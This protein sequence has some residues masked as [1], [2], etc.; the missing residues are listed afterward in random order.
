[1]LESLCGK[2][3]DRRDHWPA[4][5]NTGGP[6]SSDSVRQSHHHNQHQHQS[7]DG[8]LYSRGPNELRKLKS[9]STT[10]SEDEYGPCSV[11]SARR[12]Q[13]L[14]TDSS[15]GA[16]TASLTPIWPHSLSQHECTETGPTLGIPQSRSFSGYCRKSITMDNL[17]TRSPTFVMNSL[18]EAISADMDSSNR[19]LP[20]SKTS[21]MPQQHPPTTPT[22][23]LTITRQNAVTSEYALLSP[24]LTHARPLKLTT[25]QKISLQNTWRIMKD[26]SVDRISE[27][28][29]QKLINAQ[30]KVKDVFY[31][32]AFLTIFTRSNS[33]TT[34]RDHSR[35]LVR[36]INDLV[37]HVDKCEEQMKQIRECGMRHV[38]LRQSGFKADIWE[39]FG[40]AAIEVINE[41]D[42][43][44]SNIEAV[45]AW[46]ILIASVTDEMRHGFEKEVRRRSYTSDRPKSA[47]E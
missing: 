38:F 46:T 18:D 36:L 29:F 32:A 27:K 12:S 33:I 44:K 4:R 8:S 43:V 11:A 25:I 2:S 20:R 24:T 39:K 14:S 42:C 40:E 15:P 13:W 10:S 37:S 28:I 16:D 31:K 1:M 22:I 45:K 7:L 6:T 41:Q 34:Y 3:K 30:P 35:L 5:S 19:M 23:S 17:R 21:S 9:A 47:C 26:N